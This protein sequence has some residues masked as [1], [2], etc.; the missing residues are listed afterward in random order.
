MTK[1]IL[2]AAAALMTASASLP[3]LAE[4]KV[5]P[6]KEKTLQTQLVAQGYE[7]HRFDMEDGYIEVYA[8]KDGKRMEMYFDAKPFK[9]VDRKGDSN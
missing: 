4:S 2:I 1:R 8:L 5:D 6:A 7:V 3:V 9:Q